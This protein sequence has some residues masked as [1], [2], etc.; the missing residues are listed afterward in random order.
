MNHLVMLTINEDGE[1]ISAID[2]RWCLIDGVSGSD[3]TLCTG[4]VFGY[5]EGGARGNHKAVKRGGITCEDCLGKIE[6]YKSIR[7]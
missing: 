6:F 3:A 5:G 1:A 4:E 2:R 7:L